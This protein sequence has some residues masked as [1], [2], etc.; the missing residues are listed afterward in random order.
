MATC[1][2]PSALLVFSLGGHGLSSSEVGVAGSLFAQD[3][4][5][6]LESARTALSRG[7]G[8]DRWFTSQCYFHPNSGLCRRGT[9]VG[10]K[11]DV[12]YVCAPGGL[13]SR[14]RCPGTC[15]LAPRAECERVYE[16]VRVTVFHCQDLNLVCGSPF[17][18]ADF[19]N[20]FL[21]FLLLCL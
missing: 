10:A 14:T 19:K 8:L 2:V 16:V 17:R 6:G 18:H 21:H 9:G 1:R 20:I 13:A 12:V 4:C 15:A 3:R 11:S 7:I 5:G